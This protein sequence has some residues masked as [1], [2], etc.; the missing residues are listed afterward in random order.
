VILRRES[1]D[2]PAAIAQSA[3]AYSVVQTAR[4][5]LPEFKQ[6]RRHTVASPVRRQ[7]N[8]LAPILVYELLHLLFE[9]LA[10]TDHVALF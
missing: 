3:V 9:Q 6:E 1:L 4:A 5:V 7:R 8:S 10:A 2:C